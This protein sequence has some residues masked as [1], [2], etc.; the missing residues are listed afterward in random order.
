[1]QISQL[2]SWK[3]QH[4]GPGIRHR[5]QLPLSGAL[6]LACL[7]ALVVPPLAIPLFI[8]ALIL[9]LYRSR[10]LLIGP[11]YLICGREIVYF[12]NVQR[13]DRDDVAGFL[14]LT[15]AEGAPFVLNREKFPTNARKADKIKRNRAAKFAKVAERLI[16]HVRAANPAAD[17]RVHC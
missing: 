7:P 17:I 6:M 3:Y 16:V 14:S 15:P 11:R 8:I 4:D 5:W 12:A 9:M 1:M 2:N 10:K 13:V